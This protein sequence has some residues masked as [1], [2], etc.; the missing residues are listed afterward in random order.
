MTTPRSIS[1]IRRGLTT[2]TP[3]KLL[4]ADDRYQNTNL[5]ISKR[6]IPGSSVAT[7][8]ANSDEHRFDGSSTEDAE[9][10]KQMNDKR[11][12]KLIALRDNIVEPEY[13]GPSNPKYCLVGWGSNRGVIMKSLELL[14]KTNVGYLHYES[15]WPLKMKTI[16]TLVDDNAKLII[17]ESNATAQLGK[18]LRQNVD[19]LKWHDKWLK[20][21]GRPFYIDEISNL[22]EKLN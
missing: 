10:A 18:L 1:T 6:W 17:V 19:N 7:Y 16:E 22:I 4:N 2:E 15:I 11:L 5:G 14:K 3:K 9:T 21:D 12:R 13:I 8:K 20:Y